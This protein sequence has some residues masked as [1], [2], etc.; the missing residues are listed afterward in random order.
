MIKCWRCEK[1]V[2]PDAAVTVRW[3][4]DLSLHALCVR[5][6]V[7]MSAILEFRPKRAQWARERELWLRAAIIAMARL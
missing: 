7:T 5:C 3:E 6:A 1:K 2:D 4:Y